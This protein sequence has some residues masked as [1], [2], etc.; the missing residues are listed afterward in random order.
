MQVKKLQIEL[1]MEQQTGS[2]LRKGYIKTAYCHP[3]FL[4]YTQNISHEMLGFMEHKLGSRF[5]GEMSVTSDMQMIP[6]L[7]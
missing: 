7:W 6:P 3:D 1:D 2:K 4:T 5:L